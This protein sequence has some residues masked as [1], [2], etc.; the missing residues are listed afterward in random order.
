[1][2]MVTLFK[3]FSVGRLLKV[4][5]K[6]GFKFNMLMCWCIGKAA[7]TIPEFSLLPVGE[8][9]IKYDS[10]A[11]NVIV[12][13]K[14]GEI[15]PCDVPFSS[16]LETFNADYL[17]LTQ[18]V[19]ASCSDYSVG[20]D[21]MII[22]T[23]ALTDCYIDGAVNMYSGVFNNPFLVWGQY[24][25]RLFKVELPVSFQFHHV[26]MDGMQ[27]ACFLNALQKEIDRL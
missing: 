19:F 6:S 20:D 1:M 9:L 13:C 10:F 24:R 7:S 12:K 14:N 23:S 3:T 18:Q 11:I 26:Q 25:R 21:F 16:D 22:G 15:C 2:P 8:R 4:C 5:K 27:A 17:R